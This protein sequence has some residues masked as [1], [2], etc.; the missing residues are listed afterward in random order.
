VERLV[1]GDENVAVMKSWRHVL[2]GDTLKKLID[3]L[4]L[5]KPLNGALILKE[6]E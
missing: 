5:L 2:L 1:S 6:E 3:G 4:I